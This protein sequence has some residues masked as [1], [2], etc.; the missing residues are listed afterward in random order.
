MPKLLR[1][2]LKPLE[3]GRVAAQQANETE[4]SRPAPAMM[5]RSTHAERNCLNSGS[6]ACFKIRSIGN[7]AKNIVP[8]A[9]IHR[10]SPTLLFMVRPR[11]LQTNTNNVAADHSG[12]RRCL[13][14]FM[15]RSE[16]MH[17]PIRFPDEW[18]ERR[19]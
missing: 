10:A 6:I 4:P 15:V 19:Q 14:A 9:V 2:H 3:I 16:R 1:H 11:Y 12:E 8:S 17:V 7:S 18:A 5:P 13:A